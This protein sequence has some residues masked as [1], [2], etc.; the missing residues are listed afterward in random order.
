MLTWSDRETFEIDGI[1]YVCRP[2]GDRFASEP[3]HFC[4]VK[5]PWQV[6]WYEKLLADLVP[7]TVLEI[8]TFDGGSAA[9]FAQIAHPKKFVTVDRR[10]DRSAG[11]VDFMTRPEYSS[12]VAAYCDVDQTDAPKLREILAAEFRG[13]KIDLVI[14]DASHLVGPTRDT[15]N[16]VFPHL[17]PGATYVIEDW[18]WAHNLIGAK[19]AW[20]Q[21]VPLTVLVFGMLLACANAPKVVAN[22]NV[23]KNWALITRGEAEL[24]PETFDIA[25]FFDERGRALVPEL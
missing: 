11:L 23:Y 19:G 10:T 21:E 2:L 20:G 22:V 3:G 14:D 12:T 7:Q 1:T 13:E 16:C 9:L 4:L 5:A 18:S 24:D 17:R 6:E 8:G 25:K 15:F